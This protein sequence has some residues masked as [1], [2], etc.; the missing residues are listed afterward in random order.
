MDPRLISEL[1]ARR[2]MQTLFADLQKESR[3]WKPIYI[4]TDCDEGIT[5]K[6]RDE[7]AVWITRL[8]ADFS[9][10]P[11]TCGLA[12]LLMDRVLD[13]AKVRAKYLQC[14]AFTCL[15]IAA[16]TLMEDEDIPSTPELVRK[17]GC[18]C[19]FAEIAR[20]E[21]VILDKLHWD[22]KLPSAVDF[23][24]TLHVVTITHYPHLTSYKSLSPSEH[25]AI[26]MQKMIRCLTCHS[27]QQFSPST[28]AV[29]LISLEVQGTPAWLGVIHMLQT[30]TNVQTMQL[31]EAREAIKEL[32]GIPPLQPVTKG[33]SCTTVRPRQFSTSEEPLSKKRKVEHVLSDGVDDE[34]IYDGI[35][36][37]YGDD[38]SIGAY[39]SDMVNQ[40][41]SCGLEMHQDYDDTSNHLGL[42]LLVK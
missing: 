41:V 4:Q 42:T 38:S 39:G 10:F 19:S 9:F 24:H 21:M 3:L 27:I 13:L 18:G 17:S 30:K 35:K 2:V 28:V 31:I 33:S 23:L 29:A 16:K 20:M 26:L 40:R 12:I 37:L 25:L 7:A 32:F 14:L 8:T 6:M 5:E 15:Y 1:D 34:N 11:E 36:R 22:I